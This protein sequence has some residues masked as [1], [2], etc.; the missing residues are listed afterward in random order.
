MASELL[1]SVCEWTSAVLATPYVQPT[2]LVLGALFVANMAMYLLPELIAACYPR[3]SLRNKYGASWALVTGGSSGIGLALVRRLAAD[4]LN[5]V[6]VAYKDR[7]FD[8]NMEVIAKEFPSREFRWVRARARKRRGNGGARMEGG[9]DGVCEVM[10]TAL[11]T[12][13]PLV[14]VAPQPR[15]RSPRTCPRTRRRTW[16][17]SRRPRTTSASRWSSATL[18]TS[19]RASSTPPTPVRREV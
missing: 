3:Q 11:V 14:V 13:S 2:L 9:M 10:G 19:S 1:H 4:G 17:R 18:A 16:T 12:S 7:V 5:V 6:I 8:E 15:C